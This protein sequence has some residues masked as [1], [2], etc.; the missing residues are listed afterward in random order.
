MGDFVL[1]QL[2]R[3]IILNWT[4]GSL[5]ELEKAQRDPRHPPTQPQIWPHI[6][7][8]PSLDSTCWGFF[9]VLLPLVQHVSSA[10]SVREQKQQCDWESCTPQLANRNGKAPWIHPLGVFLATLTWQHMNDTCHWDTLIFPS[11]TPYAMPWHAL[12]TLFPQLPPVPPL[13]FTP[14]LQ[15]CQ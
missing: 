14:I 5:A 11:Q 15:L 13:S 4:V 9:V 10:D 2:W 7:T 12:G 1:I 6:L 3:G 8:C